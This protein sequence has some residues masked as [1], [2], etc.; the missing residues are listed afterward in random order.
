VAEP[1]WL[2][3]KKA[4]AYLERLGCPISHRTLEKWASKNNAGKGP[5]FTRI[6]WNIVRYARADLDAWAAREAV[7]VE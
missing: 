4:A 3:R 1:D 7:R 5:A 6:R 2:T